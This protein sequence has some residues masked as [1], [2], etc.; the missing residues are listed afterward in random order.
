MKEK[1]NLVNLDKKQLS[2]KE[3]RSNFGGALFCLCWSSCQCWLI[4]APTHEGSQMDLQNNANS[5]RAVP[6]I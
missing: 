1:L 2:Q 6:P 4:S 3:M 5:S